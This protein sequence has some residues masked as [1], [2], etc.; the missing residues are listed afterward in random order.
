[1]AEEETPP[2]EGTETKKKG[3]PPF[4]MPLVLTL[5]GIGGGG[6]IGAKVIGPKLTAGIVGTLTPAE[7]A[8]H[9]PPKRADGEDGAVADGDHAEGD[10]KEAEGEHAPAGPPPLYTITDLV[11]NPAGSGGTRFLMMSVAFDVKDSAA[12]AQLQQRDAEIKDAVL[13][14]VGAKTV[15]QL[16]EV[17]AREPLKAEIN[18]L[19][20]KIM[21]QKKIIRRVSF[22]QFVIQ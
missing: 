3:L 13:A 4:V 8:A 20:S 19:V 21:K 14:L 11:L 1:M 2:E 16:A 15:E 6:F 18:E 5:V 22:P 9:T 12:V 17:S 7:L 10:A